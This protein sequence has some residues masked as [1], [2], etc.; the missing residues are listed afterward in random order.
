MISTKDL[1]LSIE[2]VPSEW[3][4]EHYLNLSEKLVGQDIKILSVF[5]AKDKVPSMCI[6]FD[7]G[8]NRYRFKDFS[9]GKMG[10]AINLI[11]YMYNEN[12]ALAVDRITTDY[13]LFLKNNS[14]IKRPEL[15]FHDR[16]K[17]SD[18]QIR[19]WTNQDASFWGSYHITSDLLKY[20]NVQPL[21]YFTMSREEPD[22]SITS[23]TNNKAYVYGYFKDDG[24]LYK[25]YMP[26]VVDKKFMKLQNYTQ[27][28]EQLVGEKYLLIT[29]SL[30]DLMAFRR[31]GIKNIEAIAPDSE[32][33]I[34]SEGIVKKLKS[35]Y[36]KVIVLFDND[37]PGINSMKRYKELYDLDYI[38]LDLE[39]DLADA[40]KK[41]GV[42]HVREYL[43][44][45]LL[46]KINKNG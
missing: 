20:Y 23:F 16:F 7:L 26:K 40:V 29:S 12:F 32:N 17:V 44:P 9:S 11:S 18:Y 2:D 27:G 45:Q 6:F 46:E 10:D 37:E 15:V 34:L 14:F 8:F 41:Y 42:E 4:Y 13:A 5:N 21:A 43:F 25:I 33:S 36:V 3:I 39:K 28:Q 19:S 35:K 22:G 30:K 24:T 31:L 1:G 38:H